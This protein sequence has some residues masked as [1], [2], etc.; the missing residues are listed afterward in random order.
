MSRQVGR[1]GGHEIH[2]RY[3]GID[4]H[5]SPTDKI[6]SGRKLAGFTSMNFVRDTSDILCQ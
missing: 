3:L 5:P 1:S 4:V 2:P 6:R